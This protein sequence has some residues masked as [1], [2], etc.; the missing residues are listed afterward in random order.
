MDVSRSAQP[1]VD[2]QITWSNNSSGRSRHEFEGVITYLS[3]YISN[4]EFY[5][6]AVTKSK[7][8]TIQIEY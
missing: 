4:I 6:K 3:K 7:K 2:Y 5:R 1:R 8:K